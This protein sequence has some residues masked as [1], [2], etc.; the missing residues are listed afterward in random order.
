MR[1]KLR[2][3]ELVQALRELPP[4]ERLRVVR[5]ALASVEDELVSEAV[6][7]QRAPAE[8]RAAGPRHML[9]EA[10]RACDPLALEAALAAHAH[11]S[12]VLLRAIEQLA[13]APTEHGRALACIDRLRAVLVARRRARA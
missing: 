11:P 9:D 6:R 7:G 1:P 12:D 2:A 4:I 5:D 13:S 8:P 3:D 10:V